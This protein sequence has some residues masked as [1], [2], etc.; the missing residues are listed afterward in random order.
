[1]RTL[2]GAAA[3]AA[4]LLASA[5]AW[6]AAVSTSLSVQSTLLKS[7]RV[8]AAPLAFGTYRPSAGAIAAST[9]INVACTRT[10]GYGVGLSGGATSG[11]TIAQRLLANGTNT[12][13]YNLYTSATYSAIWGDGS[14]NSQILTGTGSGTATPAALTV[15][16]LL[17]DNTF[18]QTAAAG[19]YSDT[20]LVVVTF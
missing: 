6:P 7:C 1:M 19:N 3:L 5:V 18:N 15:Y 4:A 8:S 12:L 13:Q 16:G 14:G 11:G 20:I 17:P 10:T 2:S 9:I